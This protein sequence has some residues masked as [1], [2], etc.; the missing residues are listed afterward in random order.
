MD[1]VRYVRPNA[2]NA[3]SKVYGVIVSGIALQEHGPVLQEK[4]FALQA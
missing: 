3:V 1:F 2:L 4:E